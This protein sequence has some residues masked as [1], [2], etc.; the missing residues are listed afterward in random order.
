MT[1]QANIEAVAV[2]KAEVKNHCMCYEFSEDRHYFTV[3][4]PADMYPN[5]ARVAR[6]MGD[7]KA[8]GRLVEVMERHWKENG[9]S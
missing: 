3:Y 7:A 2:A 6:S 9:I 4:Y 5:G 1:I 8:L